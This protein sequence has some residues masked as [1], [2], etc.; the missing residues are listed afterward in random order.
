M[1]SGQGYSVHVVSDTGGFVA[2]VGTH[3][4][5]ASR[6]PGEPRMDISSD[7]INANARLIAA[8]PALYAACKAMVDAWASKDPLAWQPENN[9]AL[10]SGLRAALTLAT[11]GAKAAGGGE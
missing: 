8:A 3:E 2:S 11:Q 4:M 9:P 1:V 7:I 10:L 6:H 5:N